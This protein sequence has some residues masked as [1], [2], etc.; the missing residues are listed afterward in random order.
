MKDSCSCVNDHVEPPLT[1][2]MPQAIIFLEE[3]IR[4]FV[5]LKNNPDRT[6]L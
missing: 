2:W 1:E 6:A 4:A 5:R 3:Y